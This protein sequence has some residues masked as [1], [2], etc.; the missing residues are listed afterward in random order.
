MNSVSMSNELT[1]LLNG[2]NIQEQLSVSQLVEKVL[3]RNEGALTS[4]GA[5][6]A[7]TGKY[8]GRSPKDKFIVEE[9]STKD[10]IEWGS[11]NQP[12]SSES[13]D[14]LY[15]KVLDYLK[16]KEEVFSF[17]GFAGADPK[18]RLP[19]QVINEFAWH[20]LF[21]HQLFIRPTEEE[22]KGHQSHHHRRMAHRS[23]LRHDI[24]VA[25]GPGGRARGDAR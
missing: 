22:L 14:K 13:F 21:A 19:I 3:Q 7:E 1:E 8:T 6:R 12:I 25:A 20:N 17:K 18:H 16:E 9:P 4:S 5:V 15:T 23:G 2:Q 24:G 10:K 11:V